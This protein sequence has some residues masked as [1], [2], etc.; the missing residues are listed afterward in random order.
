MTFAIAIKFL[1]I[2]HY[3]NDVFLTAFFYP[4]FVLIPG[5]CLSV[6]FRCFLQIRARGMGAD[7]DEGVK[8]RRTRVVADSYM[9]QI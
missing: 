4:S 6:I 8:G 5:T 9:V 7:G 2:E 1:R 3:A